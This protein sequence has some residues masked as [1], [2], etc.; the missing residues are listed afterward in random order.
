[1]NPDSIYVFEETH[2]KTI[3]FNYMEAS[4]FS[5]YTYTVDII[6][7]KVLN[8]EDN[9][10]MGG[11]KNEFDLRVPNSA[12]IHPRYTQDFQF[13]FVFSAVDADGNDVDL[14]PEDLL[15]SVE[16]NDVLIALHL[17]GLETNIDGSDSAWVP[18]IDD[19]NTASPV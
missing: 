15:N 17:G 11:Y 4:E 13:T 18:F 19:D 8:D 9:I 6:P 12:K 2:V 14:E 10:K 5:T 3:A 7:S 1:M 16:G